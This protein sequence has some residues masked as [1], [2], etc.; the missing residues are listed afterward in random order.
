MIGLNHLFLLIILQ[1]SLIVFSLSLCCPRSG[2]VTWRGTQRCGNSSS[3]SSALFSATPTSSP[4]GEVHS[5][6]HFLPTLTLLYYTYRFRNCLYFYLTLCNTLNLTENKMTSSKGKKG[7]LTRTV[8]AETATASTAPPSSLSQ[9][10]STCNNPA[11]TTHYST[12]CRASVCRVTLL[13]FTTYF[14]SC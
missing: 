8:W 9:T 13:P 7:S 14:I 1:F 11:C 2:G 6:Q 4:S 12:S 5:F 3:P 10:S